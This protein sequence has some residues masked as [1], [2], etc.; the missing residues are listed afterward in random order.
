MMMMMIIIIIIII[1]ER[2]ESFD[3]R[4][5][6]DTSGFLFFTFKDQYHVV[7]VKM[8]SFFPYQAKNVRTIAVGIG[9]LVD[10]KELEAIAMGNKEDVISVDDFTFLASA[11]GA[12]KDTACSY[13]EFPKLPQGLSLEY[14]ELLHLACVQ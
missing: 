13:P 1:I 2:R 8:K 10:Q 14:R 11:L 6:S 5:F 7:I 3:D 9:H 12:Y 4:Y